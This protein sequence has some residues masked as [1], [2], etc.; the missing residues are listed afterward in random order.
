MADIFERDAVAVITGAASGIGRAAATHCAKAGM[1]IVLV[2]VD[3][4]KLVATRDMLG[5][6]VGLSHLYCERADVADPVP[7]A[8]RRSGQAELAGGGERPPVHEG[9]EFGPHPLDL[10]QEDVGTDVADAL[11]CR[12]QLPQRRGLPIGLVP[13]PAEFPRHVPHARGPG[14]R[15]LRRSS[16]W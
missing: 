14:G 9:G 5:D 12:E 6:I 16:G 15:R 2:D 13:E 10:A 1:R 7:E 4:A 8:L 11:V 3:E